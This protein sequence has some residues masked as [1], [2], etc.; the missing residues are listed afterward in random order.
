MRP[1]SWKRTHRSTTASTYT[2]FTSVG[3]RPMAGM[4]GTFIILSSMPNAT[5]IASNGLFSADSPSDDL[6]GGVGPV[7]DE[8]AGNV[9]LCCPCPLPPPRL[10]C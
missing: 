8:D 7:D 3:V 1:L 2:S 4:P 6:D 9:D 10:L 5:E